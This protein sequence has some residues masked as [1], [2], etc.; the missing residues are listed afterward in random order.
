MNRRVAR[1][2]ARALGELAHERDVLGQVEQDLALILE[3]LEQEGEFRRVWEHQRIAKA[4]KRK[5]LE[6]VLGN[7]ISPLTLKFLFLL[8]E[9]RREAILQDVA[10]EFSHLANQVRDVVDVEVKTA[11]AL[12]EDEREAL[13]ARLSEYLG[14]QVRIIEITAPELLG[15][16]VARVGD[17]VMDGS[18]L[19]RLRRLQEQ[20]RANRWHDEG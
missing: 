3:M 1:R 7:R 17:L 11:R 10:E 15:G 4:E 2:Y 9:K 5:I 19:N 20:L 16:V 6:Q 18:V 13:S 12:D 8:L 14:K